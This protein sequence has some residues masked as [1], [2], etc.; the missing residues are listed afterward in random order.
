MLAIIEIKTF[1]DV[2]LRDMAIGMSWRYISLT[3]LTS[4]SERRVNLSGTVE[5]MRRIATSWGMPVRARWRH[6]I[7]SH[8]LAG[9]AA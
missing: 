1:I 2:P 3:G 9:L 8:S 4:T 6:I 5:L 7:V